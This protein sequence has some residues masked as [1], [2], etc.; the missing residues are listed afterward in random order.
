MK[1][2]VAIPT[3]GAERNAQTIEGHAQVPSASAKPA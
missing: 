3:K 1:H 2:T